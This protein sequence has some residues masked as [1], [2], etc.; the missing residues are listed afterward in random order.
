MSHVHG[1]GRARGASIDIL[2]PKLAAQRSCFTDGRDKDSGQSKNETVTAT[3]PVDRHLFPDGSCGATMQDM[4]LT[5]GSN[6]Q[7]SFNLSLTFSKLPMSASGKEETVVSSV[8][9]VYNVSDLLFPDIGEIGTSFRLLCTPPL[10][11]IGFR[12]S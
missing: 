8:L 3:I 11:W 1:K 6:N 4:K 12:A 2:L 5:W 9:F 10:S 7:P